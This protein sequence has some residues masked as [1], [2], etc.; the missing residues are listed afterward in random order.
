MFFY[1]IL[2]VLWDFHL[3]FTDIDQFL[4]NISIRDP[5]HTLQKNTIRDGDSTAMN[6]MNH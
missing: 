3:I 4:F 2:L 6:H 5:T 1:S